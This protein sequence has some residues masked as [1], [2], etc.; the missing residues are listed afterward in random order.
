MCDICRIAII[1]LAMAVAGCTL[2][3]PTV[4][5]TL[6]PYDPIAASRIHEEGPN[7]IRGQA[8]LR[9]RGGGVVTCASSEVTLIPSTSY[10]LERI[11]NIYGVTTRA[12]QAYRVAD[13]P[14]PGYLRDIRTT[15]CDAQ[16]NFSFSGVADGYYF[17]TTRVVW[18]VPSGYG[19]MSTQGGSVMAPYMFGAVKSKRLLFLPRNLRRRIALRGHWQIRP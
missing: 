15:T 11:S 14:D 10:A 16:G 2:P 7:E 18:E 19:Y 17:V 5:P 3:H 12:A 8:F 1:F 4:I 6:T 13:E 9:Q